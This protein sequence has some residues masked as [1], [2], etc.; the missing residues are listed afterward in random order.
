MAT[1]DGAAEPQSVPGHVAAA[2]IDQGLQVRVALVPASV[3]RNGQSQTRGRK[4]RSWRREGPGV[5]PPPGIQI[6]DGRLRLARHGSLCPGVAATAGND[7]V[8]CCFVKG[9]WTQH[10]WT[11]RTWFVS[12]ALP[13]RTGRDWSDENDGQLCLP[14]MPSERTDGED[15]SS[16]EI[17]AIRPT[18]GAGR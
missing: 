15:A 17:D 1:T 7:G 11:G 13:L 18:V 8:G 2:A 12:S 6:G 14:I 16:H 9:R 4:Y 5:L 10:H 3:A